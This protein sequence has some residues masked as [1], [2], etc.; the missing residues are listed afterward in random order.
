MGCRLLSLLCLVYLYQNE[1]SEAVTPIVLWHGI[2]DTCCNPLS[3]GGF[4]D[5]LEKTI[6]GTTVLSLQIGD[7]F[8]SDMK[9]SYLM[10]TNDQVAEACAILANHSSILSNGYNAIGFSQGGQ[11][12]RAVA[13]RCPNP[14]MKNLVSL[15]GQHQGIFGFPKCPGASNTLCECVRKMLDYG[16]YWSWI[17]DD[18][19]P[20]QYWH[21]PLDEATYK[22]KSIFLADLN[23]ENQVN[24]TYRE[25]LKKLQNLIL[26]KFGADTV[27]Q[28]RES[29]WF[30]WYQ[31]GQDKTVV[32]MNETDLYKEDRIG[33]KF[34]NENGRLHLINV[35]DADHLQFKEEWFTENIVNQFFKD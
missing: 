10:N 26:V 1:V 13:Q 2:G 30:S 20:A 25:N 31:S 5:Y 17:Q 24:E 29:S 3:L 18:I 14:P 33:L 35:P 8:L 21:D 9:N 16:A 22:Q 4:K 6:N 15:G 7:G 32:P 27:V 28:P 19:V 23:N 12:L 34:L 11:F